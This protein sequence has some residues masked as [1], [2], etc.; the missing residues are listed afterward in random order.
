V[1]I[2][3]ADA[4]V[5]RHHAKLS[6]GAQQ[7]TLSDGGSRNGTFMN[8]ARI[9]ATAV[10]PG[11]TIRIGEGLLIVEEVIQKPHKPAAPAG[12]G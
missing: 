4:G 5:S 1:E 2:C 12:G 10:R 9:S 8:G 6:L 11:D 7:A 3:I